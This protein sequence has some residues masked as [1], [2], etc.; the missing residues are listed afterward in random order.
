M[1]SPLQT[2][3]LEC[4]KAASLLAVLKKKSPRGADSEVVMIACVL[5]RQDFDLP[6]GELIL[7]RTGTEKTTSV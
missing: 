7:H 5:C 4:L 1:I 6:L 2:D 3:G